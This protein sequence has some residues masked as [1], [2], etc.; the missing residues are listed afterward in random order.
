MAERKRTV[1]FKRHG[2]Y[3]VPTGGV[4]AMRRAA[5]ELADAD[6]RMMGDRVPRHVAPERIEPPCFRCDDPDTRMYV[7]DCR[8]I[9]P[10]LP[11]QGQADLV[12][13]DPP[14]NWE[15]PY[16]GWSDGMPRDAYE[17]FTFDWLDA[18]VNMLSLRGSLW[19]NIGDDTAAEVVMHLKRRGLHMMNWCVWHF[20]FGQNRRSSFILSKAHAL[21][22]V[23]DPLRRI[24]NPDPILEPSDRAN[25]YRDGRTLAKRRDKGLRVPLD[26]WYGAYWGRVQGNNRERRSRHHNQLPE[27]YLER[28][29][30]ACS[31]PG[32]LVIDPFSGSGT[33]ATVAR[34]LGRRS[35]SVEQLSLIHI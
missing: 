10:Q 7:G 22:F 18:C 30:K 3:K 13:A 24:W 2:G 1:G 17:R 20:R 19:V 8:D 33:A 35:I 15:V 34:A 27:P 32:G 4:A 11:E 5:D 31:R 9:L 26:V 16:E 29:I 21:Y 6:I 23:R 12:F 14:F 25:V 28:V